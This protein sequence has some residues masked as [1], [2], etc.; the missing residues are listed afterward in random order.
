MCLP[1]EMKISVGIWP[2]SWEFAPNLKFS[3]KWHKLFSFRPGNVAIWVSLL[4]NSVATL[5]C[6]SPIMRIFFVTLGIN[7]NAIRGDPLLVDG[8]GSLNFVL[9]PSRSTLKLLL[10]GKVLVFE[11]W[12]VESEFFAD[13]TPRFPPDP[14]LASCT[15]LL[16]FDPEVVGEV[17]RR[18]QARLLPRGVSQGA[19]P[20]CSLASVEEAVSNP[21]SALV[22]AGGPLVS[23]TGAGGTITLGIG[24]PLVA[25]TVSLAAELLTLVA[26]CV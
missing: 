2:G 13:A 23:G 20:A 4:S 25:V 26:G 14:G 17:L 6:S 19:L 18:L 1:K 11:C 15:T 7:Q 8:G 3:N 10:G 24:I 9:L 22:P 5:S 16:A 21:A 12:G